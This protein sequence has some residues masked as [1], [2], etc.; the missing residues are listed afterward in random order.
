MREAADRRPEPPAL[1]LASSLRKA[2]N[3]LLVVCAGI[4]AF[5]Y[6]VDIVFFPWDYR[7]PGHAPLTDDWHGELV[8]NGRP[9]QIV[10]R[11]DSTPSGRRHS[12]GKTLIVDA[13]LCDAERSRDF[14]GTSKPRGWAGASFATSLHTRDARPDGIRQISLHA[15]WDRADSLEIRARLAERPGTVV[16]HEGAPPREPPVVSAML[17]RGVVPMRNLPCEIR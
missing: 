14:H 2:R 9:T 6:A 15:R 3:Q 1:A 11:L 10:F 7:W 8:V 4:L 13:R 5:Y 16:I 17:S 12:L